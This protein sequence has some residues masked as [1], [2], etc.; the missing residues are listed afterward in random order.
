MKLKFQDVGS[1]LNFFSKLSK[2]RNAAPWNED[3]RG[4]DTI[5]GTTLKVI[6]KL[7]KLERDNFDKE[8]PIRMVIVRLGYS[9]VELAATVSERLEGK[10]VVQA[11]SVDSSMLPTTPPGNKEAAFKTK[12]QSDA[13]RTNTKKTNTVFD[14]NTDANANADA[15]ADANDQTHLQ[16]VKQ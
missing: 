11:I 1:C 12:S 14:A 15:D 8:D 4:E 2:L 9:G 6:K 10:G 7:T 5:L 16:S 13:V 3:P